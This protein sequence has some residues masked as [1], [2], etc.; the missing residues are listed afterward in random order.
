MGLIINYFKWLNGGDLNGNQ[1]IPILQK[2]GQYLNKQ[3]KDLLGD[4][5]YQIPR[6]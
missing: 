4:A 2:L 6:H 5:T 1:A 3:R